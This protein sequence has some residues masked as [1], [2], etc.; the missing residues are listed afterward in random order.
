M[1]QSPTVLHFVQKYRV[2]MR[3]TVD[4]SLAAGFIPINTRQQRASFP[5]KP[6]VL[7]RKV[8]NNDDITFCSVL[9]FAMPLCDN[10]LQPSPLCGSG[11]NLS[12]P[13][14]GCNTSH[15]GLANVNI[16]KRMFYPLRL[17]KKISVFPVT[18]LKLLGRVGTH[19][20]F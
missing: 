11:C 5:F 13:G 7:E 10:V 20:Y 16:R 1:F 3:L 8:Y 6:N 15:T 12:L 2:A 4:Q 14:S 19:I 9:T 17:N 18:G